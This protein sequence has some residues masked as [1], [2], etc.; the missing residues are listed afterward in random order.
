MAQAKQGDKV[1]VDYTGTLEDGSVFDTSFPMDGDCG[2]DGETCDDEEGCGCESGPLEFVIGAGELL[3][4]FEE[5]VV[6]MEPGETRTVK[7]P[8]ADAYGL[9]DDEQVVTVD[10]SEFPEDLEPHVGMELE[11][12]QE[13]GESL[14]VEVAAVTEDT[15][16]LDANHPLA[17]ED[18][19]FEITL[20]EIL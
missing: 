10:R 20:K 16:T 18:L 5:T 11:L 4:A 2:C 9:R 12:T 8:A 1:V 14:V 6:G 3:P 7:I 13:D 19:T 17:G 15:V